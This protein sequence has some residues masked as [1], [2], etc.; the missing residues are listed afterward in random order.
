ML[1][2][3]LVEVAEADSL[4]SFETRQFSAVLEYFELWLANN[5]SLADSPQ[6]QRSLSNK[7]IQLQV[8][9]EDFPAN[10]IDTE[11]ISAPDQ[12]AS[13]ILVKHLGESRRISSDEAFYA[14]ELDS[15]Q[16]SA[17]RDGPWTPVLAQHPVSAT[18]EFRTFTFGRE[19]A[20][21]CIP[22][23]PTPG[24]IHD[25]QFFP[26]YVAQALPVPP[27]ATDGFWGRLGESMGLSVF[28]ADYVMQGATPKIFEINPTF[29]W[30]WLPKV[31]IDAIAEAA[32]NYFNER[33]VLA[34][35]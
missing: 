35:E 33:D 24:L 1:D 26:D 34:A 10:F 16:L 6:K 27:V 13:G 29:S 21:I 2:D 12:L 20:T 23:P 4:S 32:R 7:L 15:D 30:A 22:R 11:L 18:E 8:I 3:E 25:I 28:A 17:L 31:C 5:C 14:Q 9:A 19:T